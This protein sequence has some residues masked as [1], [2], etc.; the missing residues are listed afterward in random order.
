MVR[1]VGIAAVGVLGCAAVCLAATT[2]DEAAAPATPALNAV[3]EL[4]SQTPAAT[5][6]GEANPPAPAS[7]EAVPEA[8]AQASAPP[9]ALLP[10][11]ASGLPAAVEISP[12][13]AAPAAPKTMPIYEH[14]TGKEAVHVVSAGETLAQIAKKYG[15]RVQLAA[16]MN[17]IADPARLRLGQRL[18]LS[19]RRII[20]TAWADGLV[21]DL[22]V[23][24]L[25]WIKDGEVFA[26]FP[27]AAGRENWE[28]P[29]GEYTITSRRRDPIW[30]VPLSIQREMK[31]KGEPVKKKVLPGPDNPLGK[32]WLQLSHGGIGIHGTN[33]PW[34]VGRY[35][36]HGCIR[37]RGADI[38]RLFNEIPNGTRV[39]IVDDPV[40]VARLGDGRLVIEAHASSKKKV[41]AAALAERLQQVG[42]TEDVDL[43]RAQRALRDGWGVAVDVTR[44]K[45]QEQALR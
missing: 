39:A 9:P 32:Y 20:P 7:A 6:A 44:K 18:L 33:A 17:G 13:T 16:S 19:N 15:T 45:P 38:E 22:A 21:V 5:P 3:P 11:D 28:T 24:N 4:A 36:T 10:S 14:V 27:V 26:T 12:Q 1:F 40:R 25:Y 42:L 35:A 30:R 43:E 8:P 31:E 23:L 41:T 2:S 29:P 34:T 37:L